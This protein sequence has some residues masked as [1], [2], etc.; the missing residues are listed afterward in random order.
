[1]SDTLDL[2]PEF[3]QLYER[4]RDETMTSIERMYALYKATCYIVDRKIAGD[5]VE[6]GVW[7][8]GSVMLIALTLLSR[9]C[10]DRT[11]W[12]YDTFAGMTAPSAGDVQEMSGRPASDILAENDRSED[13]PFWG[14]AE[15]SLVEANLRRTQ[16][17]IDRFRVIEG[18]VLTTIPA[19]APAE[20]ALL[21][22]DTDWYATT[23]HELE[24]LYPRI[25]PNGVVII[26]DYGY[27][28]GARKATD[29]YWA[30]LPDPPLLN[31]IDF[32]GRIAVKP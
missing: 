13:N 29:D 7:R 14:I 26:D 21:R 5:F 25:S 24:H 9:R 2:E 23:R 31:R 11:I 30:S 16:Y 3:L 32:T 19:Q 8:G 4:C 22:L 17:P 12:L 10:T 18:D 27:W 6:C 15:R 28:R 20:I 1:M